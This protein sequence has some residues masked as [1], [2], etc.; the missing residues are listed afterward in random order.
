MSADG[1]INIA[2]KAEGTDEAADALGER[3][4]A[5]AP[6]APGGDGETGLGG[7][8]GSMGKL[9]GLVGALVGILGPL[10]PFIEGILSV[11][12]AF[13]APIG[14][15]IIRL[16]MPVLR[17]LLKNLPAWTSLF[18]RVR[19]NMDI[20][21]AAILLATGLLGGIVLLLLNLDRIMAAARSVL[22]DV[23]K[24]LNGLPA[25][26][27]SKIRSGASWLTSGAA[28]IGK[29]VWRKIEAGAS[30]LTNGAA[31]IATQIWDATTRTLGDIY[32]SVTSLPTDIW[33][34]IKD[35]LPAKIGT[36]V[37]NALPSLG[38][39][40]PILPNVNNEGGVDFG[41]LGDFL[42]N[43]TGG[44]RGGGGRNQPVVNI[45]GG[46]GAFIEQVERSADVELF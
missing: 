44:N 45:G 38:T 17:F 43:A 32:D 31:N 27:W 41:I 22:D 21:G 28:N 7:G 10:L 12:T 46:L 35:Q 14:L 24:R 20:V 26:I 9:L 30:W 16:L 13:L 39:D 42:S 40:G 1:N 18:E 2:V 23:N 11:L 8:K 3:E 15:V 34:A 37:A 29:A 6:D 25:E 19:D 4:L 36:A 5:A 33:N